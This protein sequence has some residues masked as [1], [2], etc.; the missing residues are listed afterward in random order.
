MIKKFKNCPAC[1]EEM[2]VS[3]LRCKKCDLRVKKD[4][5]PCAFC[6]LPEE[7]YEFLMIFL[8]TEGKITDIEK[9]LGVSYPT[10]KSKIEHLLNNLNL[11]PYEDS[12]DPLDAIAEGKLSVDEAIAILKSKR[13]GGFK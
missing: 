13:K 11:K 10:I 3:E 1:G 6:N 8:R 7:D 4:F 9:V 2:I 5:S 12:I